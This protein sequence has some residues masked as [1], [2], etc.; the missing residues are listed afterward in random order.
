MAR[1]ENA[2]PSTT[3]HERHSPGNRRASSRCPPGLASFRTTNGAIAATAHGMLMEADDGFVE[4]FIARIPDAATL[5][6]GRKTR[7]HPACPA[8]LVAADRLE[9]AR[10]ATSA[11]TPSRPRLTPDWLARQAQRPP[12]REKGCR[13][14]IAHRGRRGATGFCLKPETGARWKR[15]KNAAKMPEKAG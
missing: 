10:A 14:H 2:L 13:V 15:R 7:R 4:A 8:H 6:N 3:Y 1:P 12:P 9:N 5:A 11:A